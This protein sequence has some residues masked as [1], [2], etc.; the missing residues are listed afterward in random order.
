M[1]VLVQESTGLY[2]T[3]TNGDSAF[4]SDNINEARRFVR[5]FT[6]GLL[7]ARLSTKSYIEEVE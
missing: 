1:Y 7:A 6:A 2:L 4:L 3:G 5:R